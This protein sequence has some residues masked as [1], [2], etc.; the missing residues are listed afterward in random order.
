MDFFKRILFQR[1]GS[2]EKGSSIA[3]P[4]P[5][6]F[7]T[8]EDLEV[9]LENLQ[10][11]LWQDTT[12][13]AIYKLITLPILGAKGSIVAYEQEVPEAVTQSE[14]V[15]KMFLYDPP[16]VGGMTTSF[17]L[18]KAQLLRG[19]A[20][21]FSIFEKVL[22]VREDGLVNYRKLAWRDPLTVQI[23][24][25]DRGGFDGF[26]QKAKVGDR[27]IDVDIPV[28]SAFL[29]TYGK[30]W[31]NLTGRS[32]FAAAYKYYKDKHTHYFLLNRRVQRDTFLPKVVSTK[33]D[34]KGQRSDG[35]LE[36]MVEE[37]SKIDYD[38]TIGL[39]EPFDL[40]VLDTKGN[41][42]GLTLAEHYNVEILRNSLCQF[43][44]LGNASNTGSWS[45][46]DDHSNLFTNSLQYLKETVEESLT[47]YVLPPLYQLNFPKPYY[48]IFRFEDFNRET[49]AALAEAFNEL[50][51]QKR[52]SDQFAEEI[53]R[54][55]A[56]RFGVDGID[57]YIK[58]A[59]LPPAPVV[60][61]A[62]PEGDEEEPDVEEGAEEEPQPEAEDAE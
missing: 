3:K 20:E 60:P 51:K 22:R 5:S 1:Q 30:E 31:D 32:E 57:E 44:V 36:S 49:L 6:Y 16:A 13:W 45:L 54:K 56:E 46:S 58:D 18:F 40:N 8:T 25:D 35:D 24:R 47:N 42:D 52:V 48:G 12:V 4:P 38:N 23:K 21:G 50:L 55:T 26:R 19:V 41:M 9:S 10:K 7:G 28:Q 62:E 14:Q 53:V 43:L 39:T 59:P 37:A 2:T 11:M 15:E 34:F 27:D 17:S 61:G 33:K 29:Y